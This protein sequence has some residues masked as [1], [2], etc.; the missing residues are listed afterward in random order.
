VSTHQ[1]YSQNPVNSRTKTREL[2]QLNSRIH[3]QKTC[4]ITGVCL[5]ETGGT[6][7]CKSLTTQ[8]ANKL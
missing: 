4:E 6:G 7:Y 3:L 5:L 1:I 8:P 2:S